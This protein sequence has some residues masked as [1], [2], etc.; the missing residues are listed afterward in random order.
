MPTISMF[1]GIINMMYFKDVD[2]H[3]LPH[4]HVMFQGK[5]SDSTSN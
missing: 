5:Q 1:Y 3:K 2:Q 4:I